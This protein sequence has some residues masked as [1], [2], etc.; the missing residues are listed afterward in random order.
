[1][2]AY[3]RPDEASR[4]PDARRVNVTFDLVPWLDPETER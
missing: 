1:V 4:P 3:R 2:A